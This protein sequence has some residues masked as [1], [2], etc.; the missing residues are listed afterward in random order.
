MTISTALAVGKILGIFVSIAA[1][2]RPLAGAGVV[3]PHVHWDVVALRRSGRAASRGDV[4][5]QKRREALHDLR[6]RVLEIPSLADVG[7]HV[8]ELE[9]VQALLCGDRGA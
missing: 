4:M 1:I 7:R 6:L 2:V 9:G 5:S 8:A 3:L